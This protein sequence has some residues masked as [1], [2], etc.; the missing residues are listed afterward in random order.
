VCGSAQTRRAGS[1]DP[2]Q[3]NLAEATMAVTF[4]SP[5]IPAGAWRRW[6]LAA[7]DMAIED[8]ARYTRK[9]LRRGEILYRAGGRCE[10]VYAIRSGFFKSS[11]AMEDG[12]EQVTAFRMAGEVL[13]LDGID[14][15]R[16][17]SEAEALEDSEVCIIPHAQLLVPEM[18]RWTY[19]V[20]SRE[21]TRDQGLMLLLGRMSSS[22]RLAVFLLNLSQRLAA[23]GMSQCD[24]HLRMTREEI[25]SY[26]GISL[27]TV[28]RLFSRFHAER[29]VEVDEKHILIL[30]YNALEALAFA[31]SEASGR[32]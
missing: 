30:D 29:L 2:W 26:L 14:N 16:H 13:G 3:K 18:Q 12:R 15:A 32:E 24:F 28:S 17:E 27:E 8:A 20:M 7:P 31:S 22:E 6:R 21:M 10:H 9:R 1:F 4:P 19:G 11:V 5:V 25:G 23:R